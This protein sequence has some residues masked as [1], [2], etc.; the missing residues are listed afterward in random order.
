MNSLVLCLQSEKT[1][2]KTNAM[3]VIMYLARESESR[4]VLATYDI[5]NMVMSTLVREQQN[6]KLN[7]D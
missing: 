3:R 2:N 7:K 1:E 4:K 6:S 5:F